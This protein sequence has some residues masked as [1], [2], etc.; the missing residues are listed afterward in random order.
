MTVK[1]V[2]I[3]RE[4][5]RDFAVNRGLVICTSFFLCFMVN[6]RMV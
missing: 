2:G 1:E 6:Y 5:S 4:E 3:I